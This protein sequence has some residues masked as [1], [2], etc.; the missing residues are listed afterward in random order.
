MMFGPKFGAF[1]QNL[2]GNPHY[3][4]LDKWMARNAYRAFG[5]LM[6]AKLGRAEGP[7]S[8]AD[9]K[10]IGEAIQRAAKKLRLTP[11]AL[12]AILWDMEQRLAVL[13]GV[14]H[15][16]DDFERGGRAILQDHGF[17]PNVLEG[18]R[19]SQVPGGNPVGGGTVP[20]DGN[21]PGGSPR[22]ARAPAG[23]RP[24]KAK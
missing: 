14:K 24:V 18:R 11:S 8:E 5:T 15:E 13:F 10:I 7:R 3:F 4:T 17:D 19:T 6:D 20:G 2:N 23:P 9:S 16:Q 12:Q 1:F 22:R 21:V